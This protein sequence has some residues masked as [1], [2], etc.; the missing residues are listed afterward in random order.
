MK[1][2]ML[3]QQQQEMAEEKL[4]AD[5]TLRGSDSDLADATLR[6]SDSE[7]VASESREEMR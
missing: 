6:D 5:A 7:K 1:G 2:E 4:L 3:Q